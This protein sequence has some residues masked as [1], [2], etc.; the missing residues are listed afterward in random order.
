[1]QIA[2]ERIL[3]AGER[4]V[5]R[6]HR[7]TDV[8]ADHA[9]MGAELKFTGI[10]AALGE[11]RRTI[12]KRARVHDRKAFIEILDALDNGY[13]P[14]YLTVTYRHFRRYIVK[15]RRA[16]EEAVLI[17]RNDAVT[18]VKHK[19]APSSMPL[20][21]QLMTDCLCSAETTGPKLMPGI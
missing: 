10:I 16:Y 8:D 17:T 5:S 19:L 11:Y 18:A 4:E 2:E 1:M 3:M 9:A 12:S 6:R 7:N 14:E 20:L 15:Y 13:R 21:I